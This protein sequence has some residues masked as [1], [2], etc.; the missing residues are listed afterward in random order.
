MSEKDVTAGRCGVSTLSKELKR[1]HNDE[2]YSKYR[3]A[4]IREKPA[5]I[6]A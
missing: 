3:E 1:G 2:K 5:K 6:T 4:I